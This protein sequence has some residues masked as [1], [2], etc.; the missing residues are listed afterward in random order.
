MK[1][2][3]II[4]VNLQHSMKKCNHKWLLLLFCLSLRCVF[5]P[6]SVK[7]PALALAFLYPKLIKR[8]VAVI[9]FKLVRNDYLVIAASHD[10]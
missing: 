9:K 2:I 8:K 5:V 4:K 6:P 1:T 7:C 10:F 3:Q